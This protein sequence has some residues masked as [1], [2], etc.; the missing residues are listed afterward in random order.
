[1]DDVDYTEVV[2]GILVNPHHL[3]CSTPLERFDI[4][5]ATSSRYVKVNLLSMYGYAAGL[6]FVQVDTN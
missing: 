4:R 2:A 5:P 1:M 3:D 6:Q